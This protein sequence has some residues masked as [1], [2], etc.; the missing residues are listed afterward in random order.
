MKIIQDK[1]LSENLRLVREMQSFFM[2][3][4]SAYNREMKYRHNMRYF[5]YLSW[6]ILG[7]VGALCLMV[8]LRGQ[9]AAVRL[10]QIVTLILLLAESVALHL[11][12]FIRIH[13]SD[14]SEVMN[15]YNRKEMFIYWLLVDS[16]S[17]RILVMKDPRTKE[18]ECAII[19]PHLF[20]K[21]NLSDFTLKGE[22]VEVDT[23]DLDQN[24]ITLG[25]YQG[26]IHMRSFT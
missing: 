20:G 9:W 12:Y 6:A 7:V 8:S 3:E 15:R 21:A 26:D 19:R 18:M 4:D 17:P 14:R 24:V 22:G 25:E 13:L 23:V 5:K 2:D 10:P 16:R 1:T 11:F